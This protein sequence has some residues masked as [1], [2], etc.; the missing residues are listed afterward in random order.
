MRAGGATALAEA[1]TAPALLQA[2][3]RWSSDT[4]NRYVR[5]NPFLFKA[6]LTGRA[7]CILPFL[8]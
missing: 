8:S 3:G 7:P 5:K 4:F 6:L 1:G 2:A